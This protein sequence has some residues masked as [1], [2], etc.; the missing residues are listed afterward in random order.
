[1][2]TFRLS[3]RVK[4]I[5]MKKDLL[6]FLDVVLLLLAFGQISRINGEKLVEKSNHPLKT[7]ILSALMPKRGEKAE[8]E[9]EEEKEQNDRGQ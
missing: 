5:A 2:L 8:E 6:L 3:T 7:L 1:M 9:E 4:S